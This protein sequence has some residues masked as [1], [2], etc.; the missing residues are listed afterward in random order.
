MKICTPSVAEMSDLEQQSVAGGNF[1]YDAGRVI[2]F[3]GIS[4]S[5][6][7]NTCTNGIAVADAIG[8]WIGH[9]A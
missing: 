3:L 5:Q 8:D 6:G 2:R 7:G 4:L 9:S 1:A